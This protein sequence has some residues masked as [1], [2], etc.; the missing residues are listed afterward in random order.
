[1]WLLV[2]RSRNDPFLEVRRHLR[3]EIRGYQLY[4]PGK[5]S[6]PKGAAHRKTVDSIHIK[7][8]QRWNTAKKIKRLLKTLLFVF[9]PFDNPDDLPARAVPR[10]CFRKPI[11][12]PAVIFGTQHAS[13]DG[14]FGTPRNKLPHQLAGKTTI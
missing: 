12:F 14:H 8:S 6:C 3:E 4:L 9:T 10:E 2:D 11:R 7:P 1:M 5:T 13:N